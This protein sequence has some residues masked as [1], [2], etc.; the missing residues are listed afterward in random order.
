MRQRITVDQ[1][2][3]V[4]QN[5]RRAR[6]FT[7]QCLMRQCHMPCT[8]RD[9]SNLYLGTWIMCESSADKSKPRHLVHMGVGVLHSDSSAPAHTL[10]LD[11]RHPLSLPTSI[12]WR[13][14]LRSRHVEC[15]DGQ[16]ILQRRIK[17]N[18]R[19]LPHRCCCLEPRHAAPTGVLTPVLPTS[20]EFLPTAS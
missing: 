6:E 18:P 12:W 19:C 8:L 9:T 7:V 15:G 17:C 10:S 20:D 1:R 3:K 4:F 14:A 11:Q 5:L 16:A 13:T 2:L